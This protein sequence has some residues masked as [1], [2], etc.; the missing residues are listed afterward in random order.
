MQAALENDNIDLPAQAMTM[1]CQLHGRL[2]R[3]FGA[4]AGV[5]EGVQCGDGVDDVDA[6]DAEQRDNDTIATALLS[7]NSL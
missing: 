2:F 3:R 1:L 6:N 7:S 4:L 5:G